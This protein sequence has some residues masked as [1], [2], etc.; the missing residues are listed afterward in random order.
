MAPPGHVIVSADYSQIELRLMAHISQDPG[1][2]R[3]FTDGMDVHRATA[4]EVFNLAAEEVTSEQRRYAK[5]INFGLIYGMGAFGLASSLGI[6]QKAARDY[7]DRYFARFA[8]VKRYMDETKA[9]AAETGYVETLFGRRIEL[10]EIRGGN[11]PLRAGAERQAINAP[12]QGTAA[13]LIKLAMLAV[14]K[15]LDDQGKG[16]RMV[17]Q[18]HDELVFEVPEA[19]VEWARVEIPKLMADVAQLSV[20]LIAE[21]GVGPN[22]DEAH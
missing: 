11:G 13:D 16:T 4:A 2:L 15:A 1:L 12:M 14:Q 20:P 6:E 21:V 5:T 9:R 7:I 10:P 19:E 17:M 8:G 3:A 18:V 22:W